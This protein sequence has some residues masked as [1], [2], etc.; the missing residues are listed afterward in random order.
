MEAPIVSRRVFLQLFAVS[1]AVRLIVPAFTPPREPYV[2]IGESVSYVGLN[3]Y[4]ENFSGTTL[5][6]SIGDWDGLGFPVELHSQG[7]TEPASMAFRFYDFDLSNFNRDLPER[8]WWDQERVKK[9][10]N[11]H[12]YVREVRFGEPV[13]VMR[14]RMS[15][16][17]LKPEQRTVIPTLVRA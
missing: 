1:A 12:A 9:Y 8:F 10:P 13:S 6:R 14:E 3:F 2:C 17:L 11:V 7:F 15:Q 5:V 16:V 4:P